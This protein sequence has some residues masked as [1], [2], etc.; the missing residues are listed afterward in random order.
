MMEI[1]GILRIERNGRPFARMAMDGKTLALTLTT[2]DDLWTA[3]RILAGTKRSAPMKSVP[4]LLKKH[5][6]KAMIYA[7]GRIIAEAGAAPPG[8][9]AGMLGYPNTAVHWKNVFIFLIA[10]AKMK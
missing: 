10:G 4:E 2:L 6:I 3:C 7:G 5:G 9:V 1:H 8:L